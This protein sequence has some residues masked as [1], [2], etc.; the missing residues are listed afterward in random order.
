MPETSHIE[1]SPGYPDERL[2][3]TGDG[4]LIATISPVDNAQDAD[5]GQYR[6]CWYEGECHGQVSYAN[7]ES[8]LHVKVNEYV[9][10]FHS[11]VAA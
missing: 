9:A 2:A 11:G 1:A 4:K 7:N 5:N 8:D 6:I 3:Y 10:Q